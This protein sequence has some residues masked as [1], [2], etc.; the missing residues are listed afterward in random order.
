MGKKEPKKICHS[1]LELVWQTY[2]P[3]NQG[4]ENLGYFAKPIIQIMRSK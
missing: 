3:G 4:W 2:N 1:Q